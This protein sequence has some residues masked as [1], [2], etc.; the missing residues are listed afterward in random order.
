[1]SIRQTMRLAYVV[2]PE[3]GIEAP[4]MDAARVAALAFNASRA[5]LGL[6]PVTHVTVYLNGQR[7]GIRPLHP[8]EGA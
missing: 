7:I 5:T 4:T 6:Q 8:Q 3:P 1:V 2:E